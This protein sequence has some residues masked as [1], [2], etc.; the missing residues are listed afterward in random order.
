MYPRMSKALR[1]LFSNKWKVTAPL[2]AETKE[3]CIFKL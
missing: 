1:K 3:Q 2:T